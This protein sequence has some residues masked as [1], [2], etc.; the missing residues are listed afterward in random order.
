MPTA[1]RGH[2]FSLEVCVAGKIGRGGGARCRDVRI[3]QHLTTATL[4]EFDGSLGAGRT[5]SG[6]DILP[7]I[8]DMPAQSRGHGTR[9]DLCC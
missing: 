6:Y 7:R 9:R 4:S 8:E 5:I 3:R 1:L 2:V